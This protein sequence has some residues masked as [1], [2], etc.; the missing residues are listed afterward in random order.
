MTDYEIDEPADLWNVIESKQTGPSSSSGSAKSPV[1]LWVKR[2]M[3]AAA[4]IAAFIT[5]SIYMLNTPHTQHNLELPDI[6][7]ATMSDNSPQNIAKKISTDLSLD[8]HL[9]HSRITSKHSICPS[10][11]EIDGEPDT[12]A[13]DKETLTISQNKRDEEHIENIAEQ[14]EQKPE[15]SIPAPYDNANPISIPAK[16]RASKP[17]S[18]SVYTSGGTGASLGFNTR[19]ESF[20]EALGPDNATWNDNPMLGIIT[21]NHGKNI[22]TDIR[23][24]LPVRAGISFAYNINEKISLESGLSYTSLVSDIKE[25]SK[26]HYYMGEQKLHYIGIPLNLKYRV[27]SWNKLDFYTSAGVLAEKCVS[28]KLHKEFI[29][30][31][32]NK[33]SQSE[34]ISD[35][36]MQWSVNASLGAQYRVINPLSIFIEPGI[37]Y[38][39]DDGTSIETIYKDKPL[40]FNLNLGIRVTFGK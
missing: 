4:M 39:F 23:H 1:L 37:S 33:G 14:H 8:K 38:Y 7:I 13:A 19:P 3:A 32:Q 12:D 28:A 31:Q 21:F 25:G 40:N 22:E 6:T 36:P 5:V 30:D 20:A 2:S 18:V 16:S 9:A 11:P 10:M 29:L 15:I 24:R 35:K 34:N 17:L 26:N 27:L